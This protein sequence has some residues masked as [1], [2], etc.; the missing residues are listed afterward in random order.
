MKPPPV[1]ADQHGQLGFTLVEVL[2]AV[3][4]L[5]VGLLGL[6][7]LQA[8]SVKMNHGAYLR[9]QA[10]TLAY[11]IA[12]AMR[13]NR[14]RILASDDENATAYNAAC[15]DDTSCNLSYARANTNVASDDMGE[16]CNR[17]ACLLPNGTGTVEIIEVIDGDGDS[18]NDQ[19][20]ARV[21]VT[22]SETRLETPA[23]G[24]TVVTQTF[25]FGT[26]L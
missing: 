14:D 10:T 23:E 2:I 5:S 17:L 22:W 12:D 20:T 16:W 19:A 15:P 11:E 6:S 7:A 8:F 25:S 18:N 4:V 9:S 26:E 13:A 24:E 1:S 21:D 3:V